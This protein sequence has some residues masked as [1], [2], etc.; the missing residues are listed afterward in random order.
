MQSKRERLE[1]VRV[2]RIE[3]G[4]KAETPGSDRNKSDEKVSLGHPRAG[5]QKRDWSQI[6]RQPWK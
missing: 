6:P 1:R 2:L 3:T 5:T 4:P